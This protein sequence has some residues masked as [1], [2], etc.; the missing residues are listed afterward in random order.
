MADSTQLNLEQLL[1]S[2]NTVRLQ[3]I[4]LDFLEGESCPVVLSKDSSGPG[5]RDF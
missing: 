3:G 1:E 5:F 2:V 4:L